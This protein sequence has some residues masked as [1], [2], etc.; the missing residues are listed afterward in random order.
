[1]ESNTAELSREEYPRYG[2]QLIMKEIGLE[3]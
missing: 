3:G 2:R 1:M